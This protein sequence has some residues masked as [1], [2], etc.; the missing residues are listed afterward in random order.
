MNPTAPSPC[1]PLLSLPAELRLYILHLHLHLTASE[2]PID[3][4]TTTL[5]TTLPLTHLPT[6][7]ASSLLA[8]FHT[9]R[10]LRREATSL[11]ASHVTLAFLPGPRSPFDRRWR[12][13]GLPL[14]GLLREG[15]AFVRVDAGGLDRG[16]GAFLPL[17]E[18]PGLREVRFQC[19]GV[20]AEGEGVDLASASGGAVEWSE[21]GGEKER[22]AV[23]GVEAVLRRH[24]WIR[25]LVE[26]GAPWSCV[27][28]SVVL[29]PGK[30]EVGGRT[31]EWRCTVDPRALM[32]TGTKVVVRDASWMGG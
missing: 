8:N 10:L 29:D 30:G 13:A 14:P 23:R 22:W 25:A 20:R 4:W 18:L 27:F 19:V 6:A 16:G 12:T 24:R 2:I 5:Q 3:I 17:G 11:L 26:G 15:L 1:S 28:E 9:N 31:V 7:S 21:S 32:V